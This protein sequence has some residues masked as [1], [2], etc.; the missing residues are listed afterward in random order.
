MITAKPDIKKKPLDKVE[1]VVL[2]CDGVWETKTNDEVGMLVYEHTVKKKQKINKVVE[3]T[4]DKLIA[5]DCNDENGLDNMT[6][7]AVKL[8]K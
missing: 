2:G 8:K 7:V 4:L 1:M 6:L 5:P 3:E